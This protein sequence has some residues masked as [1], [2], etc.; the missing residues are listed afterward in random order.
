M[1]FDC[2]ACNRPTEH[3]FLYT[4]NSCA[5]VKCSA[6]GLGR[7]RYEE[8]APNDFYSADYFSGGRTDGYADYRGAEA[9]LRREFSH[10]LKFIRAYQAGGRLLEI[11]CA[12]G[13]FL[14]EAAASYEV[15]GIEIAEAP[16]RYCR[17]QGLH[18]LTGIAEECNLAA[19]GMMDVIVMLDVIEHL[20]DPRATL[21]LCRRHLNPG[22]IIVL[23]TGDFGSLYARL[24]GPHWRLMTPPRHLWYFTIESVR[25]MAHAL[26]LKV[27]GCDRPWKL[28]P[29]SL[30]EFQASRMLGIRY[31]GKFA[32]SRAGI[33]VNLF[34]VMRC[35]ISN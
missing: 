16:A 4:K 14:K 29:L 10:S 31:S 35:V 20:P 2:P 8:F 25:R 18:V 19:L 21:R 15:A 22:G 28:V 6:C 32:G 7:A 33:P 34:D 26:G 11:G 27:E 1:Q 12:Y 5:I 24:T 23:T 9:I 13:F 17:E 3:Q 30:I